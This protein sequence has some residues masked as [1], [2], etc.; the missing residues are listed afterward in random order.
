MPLLGGR[1]EQKMFIGYA[2]G[3]A[4]ITLVQ[5]LSQSHIRW[6]TSKL[7]WILGAILVWCTFSV[8]WSVNLYEWNLKW[9][10]L[11]VGVQALFIVQQFTLNDKQLVT[12]FNAMFFSGLA[13][14][15][16]GI[17]QYW[18]SVEWYQQAAPPASG[19]GNKN[20]AAHYI[21]LTLWIGVG[22]FLYTKQNHL[23]WLYSISFGL[24]VSYILYTGTRAAWLALFIQSIVFTALLLI[25]TSFYQQL[26]KHYKPVITSLVLI[27]AMAHID[28]QGFNPSTLGNLSEQATSI[29]E[30]SQITS[31][32]GN[33]RWAIYLN[34]LLMIKEQ[35]L[36][37][38]GLGQ[39]KLYY[40]KYQQQWI[41]DKLTTEHNQ[42]LKAHNELI[43]YLAEL[44]L[45]GLLLI[46][47]LG[48]LT[49]RYL[50]Q[51]IQSKLILN[52][53]SGIIVLV[54]LLGIMVDAQFSFP[55]QLP[56]PLVLCMLMIT[57]ISIRY[58]KLESGNNVIHLPITLSYKATAGALLCLLAIFSY[59]WEQSEQAWLRAKAYESHL[60]FDKLI[61]EAKQSQMWIPW[62]HEAQYFVA[63]GM[64]HKN[65]HRSAVDIYQ[66]L[67]QYFPHSSSALLRV[68]Q[69][70]MFDKQFDTAKKYLEQLLTQ[71]PYSAEANKHMGLLYFNFL[72]DKV[73][74]ANYFKQALV[75][76]PQ[77]SQHQQLRKIVQKYVKGQQ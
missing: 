47:I 72:N 48:I 67:F 39:W 15:I 27:G 7:F 26:I 68:G 12:L 76:D 56:A 75:L 4:I 22:L 43:E 77:I 16:M 69:S 55:L 46:V 35:G 33:A 8:L 52:Q 57:L 41:V 5:L 24:M 36:L 58:S 63:F 60:N 19:F 37:G 6:V 44:G 42:P 49:I 25:N 54:A 53:L 45:V 11:L 21:I 73:K 20:M 14:A 61:S 40:P 38:V 30:E 51:L 10:Y 71:R 50:W 64:Q 32:T 59:R 66:K 9:L 1:P 18:F 3:F 29:I 62:R 2:I 74:G 17:F 31:A 13:V 28:N 65:Q 70:A 34:S 23:K